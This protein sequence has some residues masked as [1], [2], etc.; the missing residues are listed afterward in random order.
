METNMST[1]S[2]RGEIETNK[3][4]TIYKVVDIP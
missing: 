4:R 2:I 3:T 1:S